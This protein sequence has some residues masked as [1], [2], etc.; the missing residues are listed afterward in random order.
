M[1]VN[2]VPPGVAGDIETT[3]MTA[4][5][6]TPSA[7]RDFIRRWEASGA[8]ERA[9]YALFLAELCDLL[10]VPG[11]EPTRPDDADNAYVF[12]RSV[13]FQNGDGTTSVGRVNLYKRGCFVLEAKQGSEKTQGDG[14][15]LVLPK[16]PKRKGTAVRGTAGW[17]DAMLAVRGQ[18]EQ[19]VKALTARKPTPP[20]LVVV[21][22]GQTIELYTDFTRQGRTYTPFPDALTHRIKLR[23]LATEAVRERL[24][25]VWTDPLG[26]DPLE[27]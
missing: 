10:H 3:F 11:P 26:L 8:A 15:A 18:A 22:V 4:P 21:E 20:F 14:V 24:A 25:L 12:E 27:A 16:R 23:D 6:M 7:A 5:S 9:N 1:S 13:T 19:Y 17:N 2:L